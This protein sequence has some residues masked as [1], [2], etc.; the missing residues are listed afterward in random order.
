MLTLRSGLAYQQVHVIR[1]PMSLVH[2][3]PPVAGE[4]PVRSDSSANEPHTFGMGIHLRR[5]SVSAEQS[6]LRHPH[7]TERV[8]V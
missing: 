4:F 7:T 6:G 2:L 5:V 3:P 1:A 8:T